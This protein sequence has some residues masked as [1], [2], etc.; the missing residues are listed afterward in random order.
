MLHFLQHLLFRQTIAIAIAS[1]IAGIF[2]FFLQEQQSILHGSLLR[3]LL[4]ISI[5]SFSRCR[6]HDR[7]LHL[8]GTTV[9]LLLLAATARRDVTRTF[10]NV[11]G[12][13]SASDCGQ[14]NAII[15]HV[16]QLVVTVVVNACYI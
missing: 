16:D 13:G 6:T 4:Q 7:L 15:R 8:P 2:Q 9:P 5:P 10:L 11:P 1:S 12:R 14:A 3:M